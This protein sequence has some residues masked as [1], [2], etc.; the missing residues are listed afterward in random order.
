MNSKVCNCLL[1]DS[2]ETEDKT[3]KDADPTPVPSKE[4]KGEEKKDEKKEE[5]KKQEE[6]IQKMLAG[7]DTVVIF[8]E[9][10]SD[11]DETENQEG[12]EDL[13]VQNFPIL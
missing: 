9:S 13:A 8:P 3:E 1:S 4:E 5:G 10:V 11:H 2:T 6:G 12:E 7:N